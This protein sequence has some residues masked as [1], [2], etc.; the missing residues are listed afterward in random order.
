VV[1][2][3]AVLLSV[4]AF[5]LIYSM[6]WLNHKDAKTELQRRHDSTATMPWFNRND[7]GTSVS[8]NAVSHKGRT[9]S[10]EP[11]ARKE[12]HVQV[13]RRTDGRDDRGNADHSTPIVSSIV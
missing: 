11:E 2:G 7:I 6:P 10:P 13:E 3:I 12:L 8:S 4:K 1:V 9:V 5:H